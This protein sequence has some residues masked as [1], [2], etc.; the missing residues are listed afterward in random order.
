MPKGGAVLV[1]VSLL[2][3]MGLDLKE[4]HVVAGY[5]SEVQALTRAS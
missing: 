4:S 2:R 1:Y 3:W 5:Q